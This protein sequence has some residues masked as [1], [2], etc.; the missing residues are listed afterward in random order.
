MSEKATLAVIGGSGLYNMPGLQNIQ[1]HVVQTPFGNPSSPIIVE[2]EGQRIA[3]LARHGS[4][5]ISCRA[6]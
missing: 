6:K 3:F 1:E 4:A 2:L 5:I